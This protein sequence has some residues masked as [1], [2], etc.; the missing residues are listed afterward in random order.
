LLLGALVTALVLPRELGAPARADTS[1]L[2]KVENDVARRWPGIVHI[3]AGHL[4]KL[5]Q[6]DTTSLFDVREEEEYQ[7]SHIQGALRIK[8]TTQKEEFLL[9]H[10]NA[11]HG[12]VVVFYCAVGQRSS[13]LANNLVRDLK[14]QGALEVYNLKGGIFA[15]HNEAYPLVDG[16]GPTN[17]VHPYNQF[18]GRF[19]TRQHLVR[20]NPQ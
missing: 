10:G 19:L 12:R 9:A 13:Q 8:P 3:P 16:T 20:T 4:A 2:H 18:W 7:V 11:I 17:F 14:A 15:W 5:M 1:L 6:E